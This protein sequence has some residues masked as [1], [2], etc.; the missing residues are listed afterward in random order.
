MTCASP[1]ATRADGT[2]TARTKGGFPHDGRVLRMVE[3]LADRKTGNQASWKA[4]IIPPKESP[5][6]VHFQINGLY[7]EVWSLGISVIVWL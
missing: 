5:Y 2:S 4:V 3:V 1:A 7:S 6:A